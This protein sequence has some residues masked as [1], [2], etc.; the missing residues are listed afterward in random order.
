MWK[1]E[2]INPVTDVPSITQPIFSCLF[3]IGEPVNC[4]MLGAVGE[5]KVGCRLASKKSTTRAPTSE[6]LVRG[7]LMSRLR[8][9]AVEIP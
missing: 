7:L 6:S 3:N 4:G 1:N 8:M 5:K 9:V 2:R